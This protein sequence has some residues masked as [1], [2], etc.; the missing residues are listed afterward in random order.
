MKR[1]L[2]LY[3]G[4]GG[5]TKGFQQ[6]GFFVVG[7]DL[8]PQPRY[9]G[10]AFVQMDALEAM[11]ILNTGGCIVDTTG[12]EW[13]LNDFAAISASPQCQG[14]SVTQS[15]WGNEYP[16]QIEDV[17]RL[18]KASG[19]PYIIENV[20]GAPLENP[21]ML[22]GTMFGLP[23]VRH[24]LFE[25]NPPLYFPPAPCAHTR[26]VVKVGIL[27]TENE[28]VA[29]AGHFAGVD[30]VRAVSG[31]DWTNRGELAQ[32]IP[33]VFTRWIGEQLMIELEIA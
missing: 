26:R 30:R 9:C 1:L 19:K 16:M 7:V 22:C 10:D 29:M 13:Y 12:H 20:P 3:C 21:L 33:P 24:R 15:I 4:A 11:G 23:L 32:A 8:Y 17:R 27:P 18:L 2:D 25:C 14:Y 31:I 5:C 6:A 28:F